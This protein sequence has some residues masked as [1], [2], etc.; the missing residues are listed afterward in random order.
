MYSYLLKIKTTRIYIYVVLTI[1]TICYINSR[2]RRL[3][4]ELYHTGNIYTLFSETIGTLQ[5]TK[6]HRVIFRFHSP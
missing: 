3:M 1:I 4:D 2:I 6:L 5:E